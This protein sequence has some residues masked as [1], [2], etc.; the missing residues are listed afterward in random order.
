MISICSSRIF[1]TVKIFKTVRIR[2]LQDYHSSQ[3]T[4]MFGEPA[5]IS[6]QLTTS[7][8]ISHNKRSNQDKISDYPIKSSMVFVLRICLKQYGNELQQLYNQSTGSNP[9]SFR[10]CCGQPAAIHRNGTLA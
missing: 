5:I 4:A 7:Q 1:R 10:N 3:G 9:E 6:A 8:T 2:Y